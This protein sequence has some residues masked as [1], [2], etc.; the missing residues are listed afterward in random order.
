MAKK[1][2]VLKADSCFALK[3]ANFI[4]TTENFSI[5][6]LEC[7]I[8]AL[9][10]NDSQQARRCIEFALSKTAEAGNM[11]LKIKQKAVISP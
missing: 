9:S 2:A 6:P 4:S 5:S 10:S 7:A 3:K 1:G 11:R 8:R